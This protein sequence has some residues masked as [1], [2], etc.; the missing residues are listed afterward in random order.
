MERVIAQLLLEIL[1]RTKSLWLYFSNGTQW[2][3]S[4]CP[5]VASLGNT[6]RVLVPASKSMFGHVFTTRGGGRVL[7][8]R[9][10]TYLPFA[11]HSNFRKKRFVLLVIS[12]FLRFEKAIRKR[13]NT[14]RCLAVKGALLGTRHPRKEKKLRCKM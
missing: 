10:P 13:P 12:F 6:V 7:F 8:V 3:T 2:S 5:I 14:V 4:R 1:R 11:F 9:Q